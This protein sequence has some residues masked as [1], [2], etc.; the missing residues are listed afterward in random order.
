MFNIFKKNTERQQPDAK[1][2]RGEMLQ[3]VKEELQ[4]LE[5]GE[6][7]SLSVLSLVLHPPEEEVFVYRAAVY[8]G[9]DQRFR[10]EV[11]RIADDYALELP[12]DWQLEIAFLQ[13]QPQGFKAWKG[14]H[15]GI[16]LT[17]ASAEASQE[18]KSSVARIRVLKGQ[19]EQPEYLLQPS[20]GR[21]NIGR[22]TQTDLSDGSVRIN[23]LVFPD[24]ADF[25]GNQYVSRQHAHV[26]WEKDTGVYRFFADAGGLPPANKTKIRFSKDHVVRKLTSAEIGYPLSEGDQLILADSVVLEF[27]LI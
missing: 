12:D 6:G 1:W 16:R 9:D 22:G 24:D 19:A 17:M 26:V 13:G 27:T 8:N 3:L 25:A 15:G 20:P 10:Q 4:L 23:Q 14:I 7:R 2:L 11:Q 21:I 18:V 5:G